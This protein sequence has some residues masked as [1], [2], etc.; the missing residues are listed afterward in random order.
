MARSFRWFGA[1]VIAAGLICPAAAQTTG[2]PKPHAH[3]RRH[4]E[5][6][7]AVPPSAQ[8]ETPSWLTLGPDAAASGHGANYVTST[9]DQSPAVQGTFQGQRGR[10]RVIPDYGVPGA[11]LR[12][13]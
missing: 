8:A 6:R 12:L 7:G 11:P 10:E 4:V 2:A 9:F 3:P 5:T 13:Y 1:A